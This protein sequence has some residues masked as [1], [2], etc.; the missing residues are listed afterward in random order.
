MHGLEIYPDTLDAQSCDYIINLFNN[1]DRKTQGITADGIMDGRKK[2]TDV[3]CNFLHHEFKLYSD[4]ILPAVQTMVDKI[5]QQYMFLDYC[6]YW[7]VCPW[8]NI[9]Y[10]K[11]GEGYSQAHC[12]HSSTYPNRM[13]AWMIYLNNAKCGTEFPYQQIKV[14]ALRGQGAMWSAAWTHPHKGVT[15]NIGDK[16]IVTGWCEYFDH[17]RQEERYLQNTKSDLLPH[18]SLQWVTD[19]VRGDT[20]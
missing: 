18:Q 16:Y 5:K 3:Y 2:S 12:E 20:E 9:Q 7:R 14:R 10:Y 19:I 15:P 17:T 11:D 8:Y 4:I 6:D 1:D 13:L